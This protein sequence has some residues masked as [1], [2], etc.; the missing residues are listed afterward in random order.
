MLQE[1]TSNI[2]DVNT[3]LK[4]KLNGADIWIPYFTTDPSL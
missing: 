4:V 1:T 2:A 3:Y